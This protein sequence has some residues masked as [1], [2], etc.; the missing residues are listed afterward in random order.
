MTESKYTNISIHSIQQ[1]PDDT[2]KR[3]RGYKDISK[4]DSVFFV[5]FIVRPIMKQIST[6]R[7]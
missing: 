1:L 2:E 6:E 4:W 7:D 3:K 5:N